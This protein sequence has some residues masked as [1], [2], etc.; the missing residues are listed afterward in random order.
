MQKVFD[1][2]ENIINIILFH[3]NFKKASVAKSSHTSYFP[4]GFYFDFWLYNNSQ[5]LY[6]VVFVLLTMPGKVL[7]KNKKNE[8]VNVK[9]VMAL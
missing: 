7:K 8:A 4:L 5:F 9:V 6:K 3:C 1:Q 2:Q